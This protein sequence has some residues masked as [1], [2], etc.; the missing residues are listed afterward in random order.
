MP[1]IRPL[2]ALIG[3]LAFTAFSPAAFAGCG[4]AAQGPSA[5]N[6]GSVYTASPY[7]TAP[8][9]VAY[10]Q[11]YD[12][13]KTV[14]FK[15]TPNMN[16]LRV[17]SGAALAPLS[18]AP[19]AFWGGCSNASGAPVS[20]PYCGA[21][22][23]P[24][25]V[26]APQIAPRPVYRPASRPVQLAPAP[27]TQN[28]LQGHAYVSYDTIVH[29]VP[30]VVATASE[31]AQLRSRQTV[32]SSYGGSSYGSGGWKQVS[33]PTVVDGM[34]ATQVLCKQPDPA[35]VMAQAQQSYQV[36]RPVVEVRYPV[37]VQVQAQSLPYCSA[38]A[39]RKHAGRYGY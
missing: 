10:G 15:Q 12:Y 7:Q 22:A 35:P 3:G 31:T 5:C 11:P 27:V 1:A 37:P 34:L 30:P 32:T 21:Q 33:G 4:S 2:A 23:A 39:P 14:G 29:R 24:R 16:V 18:G 36:V 38:P 26:M 6:P 9:N 13:L 17:Q 19:N 8:V 20:G 25:P 28:R